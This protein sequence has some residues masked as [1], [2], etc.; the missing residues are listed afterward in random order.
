VKSKID[1]GTTFSFCVRVKEV[2]SSVAN[3]LT[4]PDNT[5]DDYDGIPNIPISNEI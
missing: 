2:K 5:N 1:K 4:S 3:V